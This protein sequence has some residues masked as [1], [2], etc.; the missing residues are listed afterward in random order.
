[1]RGVDDAHVRA[2]RRAEVDG[3]A[4]GPLRSISF[5]K[6]ARAAARRARVGLGNEGVVM[7]APVAKYEAQR[8][9]EVI[10]RMAEVI[11]AKEAEH[12]ELFWFLAYWAMG[13]RYSAEEANAA[14]GPILPRLLAY[15][16]FKNSLS[17]AYHAGVSK[18]LNEGALAACRQ[19]IFE[20]GVQRLGEP[21]ADLR[22]VIGSIESLDRLEQLTARVLKDN[23]WDSVMKPG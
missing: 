10:R 11:D 17:N 16:I 13:L 3:R 8:F 15:E 20:P 18:G 22:Q 7:F 5:Q 6:N 19:W 21:G 2:R 23:D 1:M 9:P 12:Q 14:L 4:G